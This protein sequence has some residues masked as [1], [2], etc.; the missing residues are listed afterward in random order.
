[1]NVSPYTS[2][3]QNNAQSKLHRNRFIRYIMASRIVFVCALV[4]LCWPASVGAQHEITS[5]DYN[6]DIIESK[7]PCSNKVNRF[8]VDNLLSSLNPV[9]FER[10]VEIS[11]KLAWTCYTINTKTEVKGFIYGTRVTDRSACFEKLLKHS[12]AYCGFDRIDIIGVQSAKNGIMHQFQMILDQHHAMA[13]QAGIDSVTD[14]V[15]TIERAQTEAIEYQRE[16]ISL[17]QQLQDTAI[18]ISRVTYDISDSQETSIRLQK[19]A[20]DLQKVSLDFQEKLNGTANGLYENQ[21]RSLML[22]EMAFEMQ[23]RLEEAANDIMASQEASFELQKEIR[24]VQEEM[25]GNQEILLEGQDRLMKGQR[26]IID[27]QLESMDTLNAMVEMINYIYDQTSKYFPEFKAAFEYIGHQV[28][29]IKSVVDTTW[30]L[31][32]FALIQTLSIILS[33]KVVQNMSALESVI[34]HGITYAVSAIVVTTYNGCGWYVTIAQVLGI[35]LLTVFKP[36]HSQLAIQNYKKTLDMFDSMND[37][38]VIIDENVSSLINKPQALEPYPNYDVIIEQNEK[39]NE[40]LK[41]LLD[42]VRPKKIAVQPPD[43]CTE[44][45]GAICGFVGGKKKTP[46]KCKHNLCPTCGRCK[47]YH[48]TCNE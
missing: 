24:D 31:F 7:A 3:N 32:M 27:A 18:E 4:I 23:L 29:K 38:L 11:G 22:Q 10:I 37:R 9:D 44:D 5:F 16:A 26:D 8:I 2:D 28:R 14:I 46:C 35:L 40:L 41:N 15:G 47:R 13:V 19:T 43:S 17:Q 20:I 1:M 42:I 39:T 36:S 21:N 45:N 6:A 48:C 33:T 30:Y 34:I 12:D 25:R